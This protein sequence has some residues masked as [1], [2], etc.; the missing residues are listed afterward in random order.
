MEAFSSLLKSDLADRFD[1]CGEPTMKLFDYIEVFYHQRR[2]HS[3]IGYMSPAIFE[4]RGCDAVVM[5]TAGRV[6]RPYRGLGGH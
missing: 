1:S 4:R 5:P 3:T 2:R 6:R